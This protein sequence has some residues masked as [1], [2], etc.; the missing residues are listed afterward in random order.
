[1]WTAVWAP[2]SERCLS[3]GVVSGHSAAHAADHPHQN[4]ASV[5]AVPFVYQMP[6]S[7]CCA[8]QLDEL[9]AVEVAELRRCTARLA[10]LQA[11]LSSKPSRWEVCT[12][13]SMH[14]SGHQAPSCCHAIMGTSVCCALLLPANSHRGRTLQEIGLPRKDALLE[15][16]RRRLDRL[17]VDH[18]LRRGYLTSAL[19]LARDSSIQVLARPSSCAAVRAPSTAAWAPIEDSGCPTKAACNIRGNIRGGRPRL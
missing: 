16:N 18:L 9:D 5:S 7:D 8:L 17:L 14:T 10:H 6:Y 11:G 12:V 19:H 4:P 15:W 13:Q 1:M 3:L 2:S